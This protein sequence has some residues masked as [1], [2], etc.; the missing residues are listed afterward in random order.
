MRLQLRLHMLFYGCWHASAA[1][2]LYCL[3]RTS[4]NGKN[5][6]LVMSQR[7]QSELLQFYKICSRR[8]FPLRKCFLLKIYDGN[9]LRRSFRRADK[10]TSGKK[11]RKCGNLLGATAM[12]RYFLLTKKQQ[13]CTSC[14]KSRG[15]CESV[16]HVLPVC[17]VHGR[18]VAVAPQH[19]GGGQDVQRGVK[20]Q[21]NTDT[22]K[23]QTAWLK[24]DFSDIWWV[25][26]I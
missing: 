1:I 2:S 21:S 9:V 15:G 14:A 18:R 3:T 4:H 12:L 23:T 19:N 5:C 10:Q 17:R 20:L 6:P 7:G 8:V 25:P 13:M 11:N 24:I 16:L 26:K 22:Q